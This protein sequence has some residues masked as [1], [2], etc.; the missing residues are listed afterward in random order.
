MR[1][2]RA[3]LTLILLLGSFVA[4]GARAQTPP[5]WLQPV[6]PFRIAGNLYYVGSKELASYLVATPEGHLL[7]NS[8]LEASVPLLKESVEKLGFRFTDVKILLIS[9]AHF[10]HDAGSA[11]IKK[12]TH[13]RYMVMDGDVAVVESGGKADFQYPD[14]GYPPAKVDRILHDGDRVEIGG[15]TLVAHLTPGHTRGCTTW[16]LRVAEGGRTYDAVIVGSPN[17][18]PGYRLVGN[19]SY[20]RIADD[21]ERTFRVLK[22]LPCDLFLG[23]HGSYFDLTAKAARRKPGSKENPFVDPGGYREFVSDRENAFRE[24]LAKQRGEAAARR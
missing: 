2:R 23:A 20:P 7:V 18:N 22:S 10:D 3:P 14:H 13:A 4:R 9:H 19:A 21:Y 15:S 17:V 24:E 16:T 5:E 1:H 12:L 6:E 8:D 11:A